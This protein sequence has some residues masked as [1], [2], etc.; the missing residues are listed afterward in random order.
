MIVAAAN[1]TLR[2]VSASVMAPSTNPIPDGVG[3]TIRNK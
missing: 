2:V 1:G 3:E